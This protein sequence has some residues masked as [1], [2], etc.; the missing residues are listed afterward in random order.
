M[1]TDEEII[2][3]LEEFGAYV[4]SRWVQPTPDQDARIRGRIL[5]ALAETPLDT[6]PQ[7]AP[8]FVSPAPTFFAILRT[9][10]GRAFAPRPMIA[11]LAVFLVIGVA[12]SSQFDRIREGESDGAQPDAVS[13]GVEDIGSF[14]Q[15]V[16]GARPAEV[17]LSRTAPIA[18]SLSSQPR[19]P[20][21]AGA[22]RP[23]TPLTFVRS[24]HSQPLAISVNSPT[25]LPI[26][27]SVNSQ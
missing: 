2:K 20:R 5:A 3:Q 4:R 1:V 13:M 27:R 19:S 10:F 25:N 11:A 21:R 9:G 17:G 12:V 6:H 23:V 7:A 24:V 8:V 16:I 14:V 22:S 18:P 15:S 26:A